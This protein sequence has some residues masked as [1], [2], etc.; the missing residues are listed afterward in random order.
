MLT[1]QWDLKRE[2]PEYYWQCMANMLFTDTDLCDF[3]TYDHRMIEEKHKISHIE[4]KVI[5]EDIDRIILKLES[6][7]KEKLSLLKLLK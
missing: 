1:D 3:V 4:I 2:F 5:P 7:I 6:A